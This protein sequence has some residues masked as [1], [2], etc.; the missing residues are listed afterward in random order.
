MNNVVR[1]TAMLLVL[2]VSIVSAK[3]EDSEPYA[4]KPYVG[5]GLG[6]YTLGIDDRVGA[7]TDEALGAYL[8]A[9]VDIA[10]FLGAE[11]RL[12]TTTNEA[13]LPLLLSEIRADYIIS[14]LGKLQFPFDNGLRFY[15]LGGGT[16]A[17]IHMGS[18]VSDRMSKTGFSFGG[19]F[20]YAFS[21]ALFSPRY[22]IGVEAM[23]YWHNVDLPTLSS[24]PF[25]NPATMSIDALIGTL[26]YEF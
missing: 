7:N 19:G 10:R 4:L 13:S 22:R 14:Y 1:T 25:F 6:V 21:G 8:S 11:V 15:A 23:R 12:G 2:M 20:D 17:V 5:L 24:P 16:T 18:P 9:G 26:K 3:A